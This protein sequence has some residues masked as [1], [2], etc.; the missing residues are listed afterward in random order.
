MPLLADPLE[1]N[2]NQDENNTLSNELGSANCNRFVLG[3]ELK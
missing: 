2:C 1:E 3:H